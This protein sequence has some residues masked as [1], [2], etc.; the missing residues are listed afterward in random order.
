MEERDSGCLGQKGHSMMLR[1]VL[2]A[3]YVEFKRPYVPCAIVSMETVWN[4]VLSSSWEKIE[5][6]K[7]DVASFCLEH[8][9]GG[10]G[11]VVGSVP[12]TSPKSENSR[13][14]YQ[15]LLATNVVALDNLGAPAKVSWRESPNTDW[16]KK[17]HHR[18]HKYCIYFPLLLRLNNHGD[19]TA[20]NT[21]LV[22]GR[23]TTT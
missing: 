12:V 14:E 22:Q 21:E 13:R 16:K 4:N 5:I 10:G 3:H 1:L 17:Y 23:T 7:P 6:Y 8:S 19:R 15:H 18:V 20:N 11:T 9:G 2:N